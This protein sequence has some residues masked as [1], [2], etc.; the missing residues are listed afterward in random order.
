MAK[1]GKASKTKTG[2][3]I[4]PFRTGAA[5]IARQTRIASRKAD[6]LDAAKEQFDK[7]I[8]IIVQCN[9]DLSNGLERLRDSYQEL[10]THSVPTQVQ[11]DVLLDTT[12]LLDR[13]K[14]Y[15]EVF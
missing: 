2:A 3:K 14:R 5:A 1:L 13:I 12:R 11:Q 4:L 9:Y 15:A 7:W 10:L 6:D 8:S